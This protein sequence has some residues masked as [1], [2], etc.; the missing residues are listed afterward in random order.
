MHISTTRKGSNDKRY[1]YYDR[2]NR[3]HI[4]Y[5]D[6]KPMRKTPMIL[7]ILYWIF[8]LSVLFCGVFGMI[9]SSA[10]TTEIVLTCL[11]YV[12]IFLV[13]VSVVYFFKGVGKTARPVSEWVEVVECETCGGSYGSDEQDGCPHCRRAQEEYNMRGPEF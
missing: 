11:V 1:L 2:K 8:G 6:Y 5:C 9:T 12:I 10:S 7:Q 4:V 3:A 13:F